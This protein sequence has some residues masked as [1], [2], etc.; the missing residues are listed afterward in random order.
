MFS[1]MLE[2]ILDK[3]YGSR[4]KV[5]FELH[6]KSS[7]LIHRFGDVNKKELFVSRLPR[8]K[9]PCHPFIDSVSVVVDRNV[10]SCTC[11]PF[12]IVYYYEISKRSFRSKYIHLASFKKM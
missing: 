4:Q 7:C 5:Y 11:I 9:A 3:I 10:A 1:K 6:Q 8:I 12:H 2:V